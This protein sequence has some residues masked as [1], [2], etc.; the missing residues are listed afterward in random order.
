M[1]MSF[2]S[3][4]MHIGRTPMHALMTFRLDSQLRDGETETERKKIIKNSYWQKRAYA[5]VRIFISLI[6]TFQCGY[7]S[8][9]PLID[10]E[11]I[12]HS[13]PT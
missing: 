13:F 5:I 8:C 3:I 11:E 1:D 12:V 4:V 9:I 7:F 2:N 10:M 6:L